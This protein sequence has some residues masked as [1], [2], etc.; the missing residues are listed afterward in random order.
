MF[1][2]YIWID[3][4]TPTQT[5]RSKT[6]IIPANS[7]D[8]RSDAM[9][10]TAPYVVKFVD[11]HGDHYLAPTAETLPLWSFDG[12]STNQ[13]DGD[14]SDCVL[15]PVF[16]CPD[17]IRGKGNYLAMCEVFEADG[18][19]PHHTNTRAKL[20]AIFDNPDYAGAM[21]HEFN[22]AWFGFEQEYTLFSGA[23]PLGFAN[24]RR[25]PAAQGPYY[26][27]VG[28]DEVYGRELAEEH[29]K[30]CFDAGLTISGI[31]AEVMPGQWEFQVGPV[32]ALEGGDMLWIARWLLYRIG[33]EYGI[34]ATLD[35]KP[36]PGD[37]NGAGMHTNFSTENM[38]TPGGMTFIN[39]WCKT[40][41]SED[42]IAAHLA[43]YGDG[44]EMRLT[45]KHE[46]CS[47]TDFK[48][49]VS[50]RTASIRI[51]VQ[52]AVDG[53]GYLEDRRPN[54][55]ACPYAVATEMLETSAVSRMSLLGT[56]GASLS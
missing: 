3:G 24:D 17:P 13:A 14:S 23:T 32:T 20:R 47:I 35:P 19:T 39:G 43:A 25:F 15:K 38:R 5:L 12:S 26:C 34:N 16:V 45:G 37:W 29:A 28:A 18:V 56:T 2:E 27:G 1:V 41:A 49:G 11:D 6:K 33:E 46:T 53:H 44:L 8:V 51:P 36:V 54:A 10:S 50:D 7:L 9:T 22:G 31:N 55:N 21:V 30:K 4:S 40:A 48:Y 52:T 42:R